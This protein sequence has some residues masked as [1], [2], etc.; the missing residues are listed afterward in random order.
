M[1]ALPIFLFLSFMFI[2]N[3]SYRQDDS[4]EFICMKKH[5][6]SKTCHYNF[7][8]DGAKFRYLD[9]GCKFKKTEDVIKKAKAGEIAL[10]KEW[11]IEC[12]EPKEKPNGVKE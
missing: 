9:I 11:K 12:P 10:A 1:K 2:E 7:K 5:A 3:R 6:A 4:V 8:V